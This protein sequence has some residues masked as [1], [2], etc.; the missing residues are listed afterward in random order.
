MRNS[1][2]EKNKECPCL[3]KNITKK[4]A[5]VHRRDVREE[6]RSEQDSPQKTTGSAEKQNKN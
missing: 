3:I 5:A 2:K 6:G 1:L 4:T